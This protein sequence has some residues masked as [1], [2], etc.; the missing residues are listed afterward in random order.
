MLASRVLSQHLSVRPKSAIS[1]SR[2]FSRP[3]KASKNVDFQLVDFVRLLALLSRNS[4]PVAVAIAWLAPLTAAPL[5]ARLTQITQDLEL[6]ADLG[7]LLET[8]VLEQ[9]DRLLIELV[10]KLKLAID[11]GTPL[12]DALESLVETARSEF[13]S[14]ILA[15]AGSSETKMLIPTVFLILP[16]TVLFAIYPSLSLLG[17]G[18]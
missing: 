16:V 18:I 8:W 14:S 17:S 1:L 15:R 10:Q 7:E 13:S 4:V 2:L 12:A 11:R 9:P 3:T 5:G 6:G